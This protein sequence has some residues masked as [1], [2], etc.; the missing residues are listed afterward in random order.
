MGFNSCFELERA[1]TTNEPLFIGAIKYHIDSMTGLIYSIKELV[2]ELFP[3]ILGK[4]F[5][6]NR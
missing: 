4:L 1:T 2:W 6:E 3:E 5:E